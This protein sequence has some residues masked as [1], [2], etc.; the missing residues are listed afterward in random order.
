MKKRVFVGVLLLTALAFAAYA[1]EG[2]PP[3]IEIGVLELIIMG[4]LA[5]LFKLGNRWMDVALQRTKLRKADNEVVEELKAT[6][7]AILAEVKAGQETDRRLLREL[8]DAHLGPG[9][10]REDGGYKW[11]MPGWIEDVIGKIHDNVIKLRRQQ[12]G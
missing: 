2:D 7:H 5:P 4:V 1:Q 12:D 11:Y 9:A 8:H 10:R 6:F 3:R